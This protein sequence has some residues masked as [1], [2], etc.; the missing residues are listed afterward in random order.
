[1]PDK[2][3]RI[4]ARAYELW[5][6]EGRSHGSHE[7]HW[8]EAT[9]Q[10]EVE[11]AAEGRQPGEQAPPDPPAV[12]RSRAP[13]MAAASKASAAAPAKAKRTAKPKV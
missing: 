9:R 6:R 7:R 11:M 3:K 1:M 4:R 10:V 2:E 5:E 8:S 12:K 13:R